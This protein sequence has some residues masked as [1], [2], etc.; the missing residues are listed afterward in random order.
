MQLSESFVGSRQNSLVHMCGVRTYLPT[1]VHTICMDKLPLHSIGRYLGSYNILWL[2]H[3]M[4]ISFLFF[5]IV[6]I[7]LFPVC[8]YPIGFLS[9]FA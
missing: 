7:E 1:H 5:M 8:G 9:R 2:Q 6:D 4:I 3:W